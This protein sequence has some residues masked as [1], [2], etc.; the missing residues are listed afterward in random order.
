MFMKEWY[1]AGITKHFT[2]SFWPVES[3]RE[4]C[5]GA[6]V[7]FYLKGHVCIISM[8]LRTIYS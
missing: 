5:Q 3:S 2:Y 1:L 8:F 4:P 6:T 7:D